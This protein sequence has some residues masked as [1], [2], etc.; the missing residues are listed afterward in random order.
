MALLLEMEYALPGTPPY[1]HHAHMH[2]A[3][4]SLRGAFAKLPRNLDCLEILLPL[5]VL[6]V[7]GKLQGV[8]AQRLPMGLGVLFR[9]EVDP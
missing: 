3:D 4:A 5:Q 8:L 6:G 1:R 9:V 2:H 7:G